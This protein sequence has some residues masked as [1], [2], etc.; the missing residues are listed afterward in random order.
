MFTLISPGKVMAALV[1]IAAMTG[2]DRGTNDAAAPATAPAERF[3]A[4]VLAVLPASVSPET[5]ERGRELYRACSVCHGDE[6][7]GTQLGPPLRDGRWIHIA[8]ELPE[9]EQVI[10]SGVPQPVQYPVPMPVQGGGRFDD[11]EIRALATYVY[12]ISRDSD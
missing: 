2:C 9:I 8:G 11:D 6:G 10:R 12:A 7:R 1:C 5:L 4:A 3:S